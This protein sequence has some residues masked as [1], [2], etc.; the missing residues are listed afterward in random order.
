[1]LTVEL[2][3]LS[4]PNDYVNCNKFTQ[5]S[6]SLHFKHQFTIY[7]IL[8]PTNDHSITLNLKIT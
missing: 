2:M 6:E 1:M 3:P 5:I 8:I 4:H 7:K